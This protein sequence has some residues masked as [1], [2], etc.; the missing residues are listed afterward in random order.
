MIV[1]GGCA[2]QGYSVGIMK[3]EGKRY[4]VVPGDVA[5][6]TTYPFPVLVR[7]I[8]G[9]NNNPYPPLTNPDGSYTDVVQKC[10]AEAQA[11]ERDGVH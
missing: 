10:I 2:Y 5:N 9:V 4:P 11:L 7:E 6:A 1:T 3:F 8:P